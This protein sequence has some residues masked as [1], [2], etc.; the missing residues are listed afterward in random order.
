M[1]VTS[2][3]KFLAHPADIKINAY[4]ASLSEV[5]SNAALGMMAYVYGKK[6]VKVDKYEQIE[7]DGADTEQLLI[8]WLAKILALSSINQRSYVSFNIKEISS[9]RLVAEL[10]SGKARAV[11]EIKAVTY[12]EL[13]LK[14]LKN[15]WVATVVYD[16]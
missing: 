16:I 12:S 15:G 2:K 11:N 8:S 4:G 3:Y 13:S 14:Q 6:Q 7:I 1:V 5:F 10:G 9:Q